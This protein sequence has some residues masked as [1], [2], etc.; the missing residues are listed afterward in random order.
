MGFEPVNSWTIVQSSATRAPQLNS[1]FKRFFLTA[2][3]ISTTRCHKLRSRFFFLNA[4]HF[5]SVLCVFVQKRNLILSASNNPTQYARAG[6]QAR[7]GKS[8][9]KSK[10]GLLL[11]KGLIDVNWS[12][13][14]QSSLIELKSVVKSKLNLNFKSLSLNF[15]TNLKILKLQ[16]HFWAIRAHLAELWNTNIED[17]C[18]NRSE[19]FFLHQKVV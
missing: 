14:S 11:F 9:S 3:S 6:K 4:F 15:L 8:E 7:A 13:S 16:Q 10:P 19:I 2:D 5:R 1:H 17:P 12:H 18:I